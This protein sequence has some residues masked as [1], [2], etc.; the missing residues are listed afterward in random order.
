[1]EKLAYQTTRLRTAIQQN[2]L[3]HNNILPIPHLQNL[4][5]TSLLT[6]TQPDDRE[7]F[8]SSI[9]ILKYWKF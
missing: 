8:A 9:Y 7:E 1:M 2:I 3:A 5:L 4:S 6:L